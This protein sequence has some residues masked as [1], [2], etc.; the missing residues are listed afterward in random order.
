MMNAALIKRRRARRGWEA[1]VLVLQALPEEGLPHVCS[2]PEGTA[3]PGHPP[4]HREREQRPRLHAAIFS[5]HAGRIPNGLCTPQNGR[6]G[7]VSDGARS[8]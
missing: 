4:G 8:G 2:S 6:S 1:G 5:Q 7:G 3:A